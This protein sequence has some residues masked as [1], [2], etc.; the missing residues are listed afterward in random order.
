MATKFY[1]S[2]STPSLAPTYQGTWSPSATLN[3]QLGAQA[4]AI[5]QQ[6]AVT[7]SSATDPT[8]A[9]CIAFISDLLDTDVNFATTDT[10]SLTVGVTGTVSQNDVIRVY[11]WVTTGEDGGTV[12]GS[13]LDGTAS[14][15]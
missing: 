10:V 9:F 3:F 14:H 2:N 11:A 12:R 6:A 13:L 1:L 15:G 4:G 7:E 5:V 8:N